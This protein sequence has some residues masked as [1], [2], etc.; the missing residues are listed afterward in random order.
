MSRL[1]GVLQVTQISI[2]FFSS[3]PGKPRNFDTG[4]SINC[5][6]LKRDLKV[7]NLSVSL[8]PQ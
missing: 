1:L 5:R 7:G 2:R 3:C 4:Y 8:P 6:Q